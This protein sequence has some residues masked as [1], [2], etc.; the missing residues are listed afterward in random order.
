MI[1]TIENGICDYSDENYLKKKNP[2][3]LTLN[4]SNSIFRIV[5]STIPCAL[6][7]DYEIQQWQTF[8]PDCQ[9]LIF[10]LLEYANGIY[11]SGDN[12]E[13]AKIIREN[14]MNFIK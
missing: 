6:L 7:I 12:S 10:T 4:K 13:F 8:Q 11:A 3:S 2:N 5:S 9:R 1:W 14:N